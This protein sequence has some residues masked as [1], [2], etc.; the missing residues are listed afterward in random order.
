[1]GGSSPYTMES[2]RQEGE[3]ITDGERITKLITEF[4]SK[5]FARLP[6]EIDRDNNSQ[7]ETFITDILKREANLPTIKC[8]NNLQLSED[9]LTSFIRNS[10]N[11]IKYEYIEKQKKVVIEF[12]KR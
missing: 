6:A 12:Q 5:W 1:M 2:I 9:H 7:I 11:I 10:I 3:V 8:D 4:F